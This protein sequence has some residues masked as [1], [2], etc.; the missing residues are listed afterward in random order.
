VY[1]RFLDRGLSK[2]FAASLCKSYE[3]LVFSWIRWTI[4]TAIYVFCIMNRD[5]RI[6][7]EVR[8]K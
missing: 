6:L 1:C 8:K 7:K 3:I 5:Y 4:K 2:R